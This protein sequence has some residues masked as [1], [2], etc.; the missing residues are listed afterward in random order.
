LKLT[1]ELEDFINEESIILVL[2]YFTVQGQL[3]IYLLATT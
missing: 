3:T 2:F 1:L